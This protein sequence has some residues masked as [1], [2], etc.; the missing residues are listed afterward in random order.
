M[1][2]SGRGGAARLIT[3]LRLEPLKQRSPTPVTR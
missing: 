1:T 2:L 3:L